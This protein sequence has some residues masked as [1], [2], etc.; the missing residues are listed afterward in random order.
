MKLWLISQDK[1]NDWGTYDSA[2]VAAETEL[3]AKKMHP[4]GCREVN[5]TGD[6]YRDW[7]TLSNVNAVCIGESFDNCPRVI[8]ASFN[9]R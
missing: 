4:N 5:D 6:K 1:N 2:V 3:D 8:C 9:A 7:T